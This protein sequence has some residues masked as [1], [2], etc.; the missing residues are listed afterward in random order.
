MQLTSTYCTT[1][2]SH[3]EN[4]GWEEQHRRVRKNKHE[5]VTVGSHLG[6]VV[7]R[8]QSCI[9]GPLSQSTTRQQCLLVIYEKLVT[10]KTNNSRVCLDQVWQHFENLQKSTTFLSGFKSQKSLI[11]TKGTELKRIK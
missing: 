9:S 3:K 5:D 6:S 2:N 11:Y 7:L 10:V 1:S 4:R 8:S